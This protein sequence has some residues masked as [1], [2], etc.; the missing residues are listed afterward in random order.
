MTEST[1]PARSR[2]GR[3]ARFTPARVGHA[4]FVYACL[5]ALAAFILLPLGWM[6]TAALKP[7][8]VPVF[9]FPAEWFPTEYFNFGTFVD[10]LTQPREP[11]GRYALNS[12]LLASV[13]IVGDSI[14]S[15]M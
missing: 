4:A 6:I 14:G 15:V 12:L 13:N 11:Y 3:L 9:T 10:A 2:P 8:N 5:L 7:E 1:V